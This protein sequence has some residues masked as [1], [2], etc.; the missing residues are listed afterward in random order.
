[1]S[2]E[3]HDPN[4]TSEAERQSGSLSERVQ[5]STQEVDAAVFDLDGVLT[6]T[7]RVHATAWKEVFDAIL[8]KVEQGG[9]PFRPF[10]AEGDYRAY[11]DGRPRLDGI[12]TFLMARGVS[13]PEGLPSDPEGAATVHGLARRKNSVIQ[14]RLKEQSFP[15]RGAVELLDNLRRV[16]VKIAVASSSANCKIVLEAAGLAHLVDERVD[17]LDAQR[18]ELAGKPNPDLFTEALR[19]LGCT[20]VRAVLFEDAITGV[21]A[22]RRAGFRM[23]IGIDRGIGARGLIDH[24]ADCVIASL[25][26]VKV[27]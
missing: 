11:V 23:V 2:A 16:G 6:D 26:H 15:E 4:E 12:R 3:P 1:V 27:V 10:D 9:E 17:G 25:T 19:R 18:L 8:K 20:A 5:I 14:Q 24:G 7:A 13:L 22:G 21:E